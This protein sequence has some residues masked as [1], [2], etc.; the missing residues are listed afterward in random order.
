MNA[1][2]PLTREAFY[3]VLDFLRSGPCSVSAETL[4]AEAQ[5]LHLLPEDAT[6]AE[7]KDAKYGAGIPK[8]FLLD[9]LR[10]AAVAARELRT[11]ADSIPL[12]TSS[13]DSLLSPEF[14]AVAA[15]RE[16]LRPEV[17]PSVSSLHSRSPLRLLTIFLSSFLWHPYVSLLPLF[18]AIWLWKRETGARCPPP[19]SSI[20]HYHPVCSFLFTCF[21]S[22]SFLK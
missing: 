12:Q 18:T 20:L 7:L 3:L 14:A 8:G 10:F 13:V 2:D 4:A 6:D 1:R 21:S 19:S 5:R 16:F 15:R 9:I 22:F 17:P 11:R